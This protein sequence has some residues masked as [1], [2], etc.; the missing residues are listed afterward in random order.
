MIIFRTVAV[1]FASLIYITINPSHIYPPNLDHRDCSLVVIQIR[2]TQHIALSIFRQI[3]QS[4]AVFKN[5]QEMIR[6]CSYCAASIL[7]HI[8]LLDMLLMLL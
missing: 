2:V 3:I 5:A 6:E 4:H 7:C 8:M 1:E